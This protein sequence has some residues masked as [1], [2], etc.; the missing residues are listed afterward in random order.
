MANAPF[1]YD[2]AISFPDLRRQMNLAEPFIFAL[3]SL[4]FG[5]AHVGLSKL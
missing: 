5:I 4:T 1:N 3:L 2:R